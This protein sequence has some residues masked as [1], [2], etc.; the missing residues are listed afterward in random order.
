[1]IMIIMTSLVITIP[2]LTWYIVVFF[3]TMDGTFITLEQLI[4][5]M[6][7]HK[8]HRSTNKRYAGDNRLLCID[9]HLYPDYSD[10]VDDILENCNLELVI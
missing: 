1:M 8:G 3:M 7:S 10:V 4:L 6:Q 2:V 9:V 5:Y